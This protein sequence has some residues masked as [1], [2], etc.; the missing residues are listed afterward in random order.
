MNYWNCFKRHYF[1]FRCH[2]SYKFLVNVVFKSHNNCCISQ[3]YHFSLLIFVLDKK[4][5]SLF[6]FN[7]WALSSWLL[8]ERPQI[9][10][11][12]T[13][14]PTAH[15]RG[16]ML[17]STGSPQ[18]LRGLLRSRCHHFV[19]QQGL[20][21]MPKGGIFHD[22]LLQKRLQRHLL[23]WKVQMLQDGET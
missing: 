4:F 19:R 15:W 9:G 10:C 22:R 3:K 20:E 14:I 17:P 8:H 2:E 13:C 7:V 18:Q 11:R 23:H 6:S 1:L 12:T 5:P 21:W 16:T